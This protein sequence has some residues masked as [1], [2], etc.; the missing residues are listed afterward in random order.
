[1]IEES[2]TSHC[3]SS[4]QGNDPSSDLEKWVHQAKAMSSFR[5]NKKFGRHFVVIQRFIEPE[6]IFNLYSIVVPCVHKKG[7][8]S[9]LVT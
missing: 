3:P 4:S 2:T 6:A 9:W 5:K 8:R 1:M 7:G